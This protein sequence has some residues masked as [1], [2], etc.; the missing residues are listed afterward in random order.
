MTNL[1]RRFQSSE[2]GSALVICLAFL[3]FV[4]LIVGALLDYTYTNLVAT[5]KLKAVRSTDYNA[6]GAM[7]QAIAAIRMNTGQGFLG[8]CPS[9]HAA[10]PN[11]DGSA[12]RV[13]CTPKLMPLFQREVTL[14]V[15]P[16]TEAT[17]PCPDGKSLLRA[18]VKF[19]DYPTFGSTAIV[20][21]WSAN[22]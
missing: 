3:T 16:S 9:I 12:V 8:A 4:A 22:Q 6:D 2:E 15:C 10:A 5:N 11:A 17:T 18:N 20:E 7:E 1:R 19:Y 21:T 13:D 14:S